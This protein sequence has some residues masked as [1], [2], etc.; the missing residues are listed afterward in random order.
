[1]CI[2]EVLCNNTHIQ[3]LSIL[4]LYFNQK[5]LVGSFMYDALQFFCFEVS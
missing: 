3:G 1:M 4:V 5:H 2:T